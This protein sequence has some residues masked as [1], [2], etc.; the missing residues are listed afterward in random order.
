MGQEDNYLRQIDNLFNQVF[1]QL[2]SEMIANRV[3]EITPSQF[4]VLKWIGEKERVTVSEVAENVC[5]SLSAI[6]ALVDRLHKAGLV[7]RKRDDQDRRLVWLE[8]TDQG[9]KVLAR[10]WE[11]RRIVVEKYFRQLPIEDL[12]N[13]ISI[14]ERL[15]A[16]INHG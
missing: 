9:K 7:V 16:I 1:R 4:V 10:C 13:L 11:A 3:E 8:L 6:T 15:L 14:Y 5:V 12:K 2:H